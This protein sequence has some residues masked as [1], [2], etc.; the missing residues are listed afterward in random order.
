MCD[1]IVLSSFE[2]LLKQR[3]DY[4]NDENVVKFKNL[5]RLVKMA[6]WVPADFTLIANYIAIQYINY[7]QG[8]YVAGLEEH[9][10]FV[11]H[12]DLQYLK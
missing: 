1:R 6:F 5:E 12:I 10:I 2:K 8:Q 4:C 7:H 9:D 11:N 3:E